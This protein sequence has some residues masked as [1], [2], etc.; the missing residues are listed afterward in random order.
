MITK[1]IRVRFVF[2]FNGLLCIN[3]HI[4]VNHQLSSNYISTDLTD[5]VFE[6]RQ[7]RTY[8]GNSMHVFK[9]NLSKKILK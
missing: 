5:R 4:K 2:V 7:I 1:D 3:F 8:N 9:V 6:E